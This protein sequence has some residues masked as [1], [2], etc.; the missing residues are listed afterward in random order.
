MKVRPEQI[1]I[2]M[3]MGKEKEKKAI[4]I[5]KILIIIRIRIRKTIMNNNR[6]HQYTSPG[7]VTVTWSIVENIINNR[8]KKDKHL[9][10]TPPQ[11]FGTV[12]QKK[13]TTS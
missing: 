6:K 10:P 11:E 13:S 4:L 5:K 12:T 3:E 2:Y 9:Q 7:A 8:G 1:I